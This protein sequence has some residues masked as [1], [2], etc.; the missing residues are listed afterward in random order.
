MNFRLTETPIDRSE[1]C[2]CGDH[3]DQHGEMGCRV[4]ECRCV[5][6]EAMT[7]WAHK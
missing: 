1:W 7:G 5:A 4:R 2:R 6:F 3:I